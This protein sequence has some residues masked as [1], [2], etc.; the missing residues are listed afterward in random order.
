MRRLVLS[1]NLSTTFILF[2]EIFIFIRLI[3]YLLKL[4]LMNI[5]FCSPWFQTSKVSVIY[6]STLKSYTYIESYNNQRYLHR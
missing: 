3:R 4:R 2:T 1:R 5:Y 6:L